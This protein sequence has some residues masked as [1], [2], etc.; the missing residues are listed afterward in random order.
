MGR[1]E[2]RMPDF[3]ARRLQGAVASGA[4]VAVAVRTTQANAATPAAAAAGKDLRMHSHGRD[5]KPRGSIGKRY[6]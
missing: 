4:L 1:L 3:A 2:A 5:S 6:E